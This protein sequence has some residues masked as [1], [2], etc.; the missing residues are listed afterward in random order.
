MVRKQ[1]YCWTPYGTA[2]IGVYGHQRWTSYKVRPEGMC[3]R[4]APAD[5]RNRDLEVSALLKAVRGTLLG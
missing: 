5:N 3:L 4:S 2:F 1:G